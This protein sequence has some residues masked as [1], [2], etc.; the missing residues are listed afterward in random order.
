[1]RVAQPRGP[2]GRELERER[3]ALDDQV[4]V[5]ERLPLLESHR[6][7]LRLAAA[8]ASR[9]ATSSAGSR[10][11]TSTIS[12]PGEL[13]HPG[14]LAL[15]VVARAALHRLDVAGEQ[16][17]EA[18]RLAGRL[19]GAG[20]VGGADL[21]GGAAATIASTRASIRAY[22]A[23]RS[24]V[25]PASRVGWRMSLAPQLRSGPSGGSSS[26]A[27][28]SS[29]ARTIRWRVVRVDL[30]RRPG[31]ARGEHG[32]QRRRAAPLRARPSS[33]R[34]RPSGGGGRRSRSASAAR[35]YSPVPPTTIGAAPCGE[36]RVDLG[37]RELARTAPTLNVAS[38]GQERHQPVLERARARRGRDAREVS[39]P[40]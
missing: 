17:V 5:A 36:Q 39:S 28:S 4:V 27:S 24:I 35:R 34:G 21:L 30:R 11:V 32:V 26:P 14:E 9:A 7:E 2:R 33:A 16:L 37:V 15:G 23:S 12:T 20:G 10:P 19:R 13:A 25:S 18:E 29:S 6:R 3:V 40:A 38:T 31:R 1:M 22:S 8:R